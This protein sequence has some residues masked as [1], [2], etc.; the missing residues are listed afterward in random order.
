MTRHGRKEGRKIEL[1]FKTDLTDHPECELIGFK[2]D[3][4]RNKM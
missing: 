3:G 4:I 1:A 2:A